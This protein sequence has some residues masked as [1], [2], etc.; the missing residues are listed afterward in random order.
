MTTELASP[1]ARKAQLRSE[2]L[3]RR[4]ALELVR[5]AIWTVIVAAGPAIGAAMLIGIL[6]ALLMLVT[7]ACGTGQQFVVT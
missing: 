1:A 6:V 5:A 2:A 4:D 7:Q 3:V